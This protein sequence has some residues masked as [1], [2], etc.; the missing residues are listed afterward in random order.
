MTSKC[1][2]IKEQV[3]GVAFLPTGGPVL[4][5]LSYIFVGRD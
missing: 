4:A 3:F 5:V 1:P 2:A